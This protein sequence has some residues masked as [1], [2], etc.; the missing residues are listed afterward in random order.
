MTETNPQRLTRALFS[1]VSAAPISIYRIG[2]GLL[3]FF[4]TLRF[5]ANGWVE[6]Q[7]LSPKFHFRFEEFNF[8]PFPSD[9]G[10]WFLFIVVL[11][12]SL[13]IALGLF[14]RVA[15][16]AFFIA[17]SYI[18]VLD[19]TNYL[20][21]YYFVSLIAF[22]LILIPANKN[23]SLDVKFGFIKPSDKCAL[24][25]IR[26]L[27][28]QIAIVYFYAGFAKLNSDWLIEAQ[29]LKYWLHTAN[30]WP[31]LGDLLKQNWVAYLFSWFGAFYDLF[32][33]F[34][35]IIPRTRKVAYVFVIAFHLITWMLFPIGIFP[36]VMMFAT[37]IFFDSKFHETLINALQRIF[38][39][40]TNALSVSTYKSNRFIL[41]ILSIY[42]LFQLL[43]P[44][45]YLLKEGP[46]FWTE[47]GYRFSWRVMLMEKTGEAT[48]Y[49][50]DEQNSIEINNEDFLSPNQEKMMSTQPDMILQ[51]ANYLGHRYSDTTFNKYGIDFN[52]LKPEVHA[53]VYVTLNSRPHQLYVCKEIDLLQINPS[54]DRDWLEPY[55]NE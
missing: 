17:F 54:N 32:I 8:L 40:K 16:I 37:L 46:I 35:L 22:L 34:F 29:P 19:K 5:I 12:S 55:L 25:E 41:P 1:Q 14:Y 28:F 10:I 51:Y 30:H 52:F 20:N 33:V 21:H 26:I 47:S 24:W 50:Q 48:F 53:E 4:S 15:A 42:I 44:L 31:I 18:E 49:I 13:L 45:R 11:L 38:K 2:F 23:C 6:S 43:F 27:Q 9:S 39:K 7:Y 36:W 3:M